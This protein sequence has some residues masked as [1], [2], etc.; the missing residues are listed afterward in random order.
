MTYDVAIVGAGAAGLGAAQRLADAGAACVVLEARGRVGG[1]GHTV[2]PSGALHLDLGCGWLHS[3]D[4]NPFTVIAQA[5]GL[6]ID[7]TPAAWGRETPGF[8]MGAAERAAFG[9]AMGEIEAR[10]EEAALAPQDR[11]AAELL[12]PASPWTPL[13]NAF[14]AYYNGAEFDQVSVKD[15]AAFDDDG[16]NWRVLEGYGRAIGDLGAGLDVALETPVAAIDHAGLRLRLDT[17]KG[18]VEA[19]FAIVTIPTDLLAAGA[20]RFDPGLPAVLEAAAQLPLGLADKVFLTLDEPDALP[21]DA[22]LFGRPDRTETGS[23]YLRP[24]GRPVVE[25]YL[26]GRH[27]REL[28]AEGPGA[29]GVFAME[30]VVGLLG[31]AARRTIRPI[32]ASRWASDP[33]SRGSYSHA[34]PGHADARARLARPV[35]ERLFFAGEATSP[36][37]FSTAH[38]AYQEGVRAAEAVLSMLRSG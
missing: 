14:S 32:V 18:T 16:I 22:H 17:P 31:S 12:D 11:V 21:R 1:R 35:D 26:G 9:R 2:M 3:A 29:T 28:E 23:Y 6:T 13:L 36:H 4:R 27:A 24:F 33:W 25:A 15:Y 34:L 8:G 5:Q 10:I 20:I 37:G 19:A 38:G 30:E 7:R